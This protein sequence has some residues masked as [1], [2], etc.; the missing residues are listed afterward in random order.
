MAAPWPTLSLLLLLGTWAIPGQGGVAWS[1]GEP[2]VQLSG[3]G[4]R[5][6]GR[7]EVRWE[8]SWNRVCRDILSKVGTRDICQQ[9]GCGPPVAE[10]HQLVLVGTKEPEVRALRCP[11]RVGTLASCPWV[12]GNCT[13]HVV[14]AC[15]EPEKPSPEP[16]AMAPVTTPEPTGPARLRLVDGDF[17]CSGFVELYKEGL[18]GSVASSP[19]LGTRVCRA[20]RCGAAL[21]GGSS[22]E[23]E[24]HSHLPVRWEVTEPCESHLLTDCFNRSST[25]RGKAPAF[26]ICSGSQPQALRRLADGPTPCEGHIEVFEAGKWQVLCDR[27]T[28]RA[29]RGQELC[30]ELGC[31]NLS[32][33][34]RLQDPPALGVTCELPT[35]HLCPGSFGAPRS[36]SRTRV[37]CQ[38]SKP[39]PVGTAAGTIASICLALLLLG[40][41]LLICGPPAY[42]RLSK[43]IS[44]KKQRQWIGPTGLNQTVS[45]Q[46]SSTVA[47]RPPRAE[48]QRLQG[49]DNDYSQPPLKSSQLSAY[50]ALE[51]ACRASNPVD[52]SSDSDYD[53]H[54]AHRV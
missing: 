26:I 27:G 12:L 43:R 7:L 30:H 35:L 10:P 21:A 47:A 13:E 34:T 36:C 17:G 31:G 48:P 45:F 50:P 16:T 29:R 53:L 28:E 20:L 5:C 32:S 33:S 1:P 40:V 18:W 4:C 8:G 38:D 51:G 11:A 39:H 15:R 46:R 25:R 49:G 52:N 24:R 42:R 19:G 41:L 37:V 22:A 6:A 23:P 3:G 44:K 14:L 2:P 54:C 9:L